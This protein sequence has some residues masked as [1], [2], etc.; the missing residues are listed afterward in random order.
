V[1]LERGPLSLVR[2]TEDLFQGH[3]GSGLEHQN[4]R[5]WG[6]IALT[7]RHP[8]SA[9]LGTNFADKRQSLGRYSSVA[10][11]RPQSLFPFVKARQR[12]HAYFRSCVT[13]FLDHFD[14]NNSY[15]I[16]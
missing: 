1:G 7:T 11:Y 13:Y 5:T 2:I 15:I 14:S 8:L 4:E 3:R 12:K 6:F 16:Q 10:D 9:K